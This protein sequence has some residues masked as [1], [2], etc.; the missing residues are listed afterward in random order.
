MQALSVRP[1]LAR[2]AFAVQKASLSRCSRVQ[3]AVRVYATQQKQDEKSLQE[4]LALP[5]AALLGAALLF[6]AT[7]DEAEAARSGGR[8]GGS[9]GF[10]SR[11]STS[12][13]ATRPQ[14]NRTVIQNNTYVAPP[15]FGGFGFPMFG[16]FGFYPVFG[17][18]LG[19][20]FNIMLLGIVIQV[21]FAV[22][23][24]FTNQKKKASLDDEVW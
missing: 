12:R 1:P 2:K 24:G 17:V 9:S 3:R 14:T 11:A 20:I 4:K 21:V 16:G 15:V 7:P 18:G 19:T 10:S 5:A 8:V 23:S 13:A 22:V 6:A